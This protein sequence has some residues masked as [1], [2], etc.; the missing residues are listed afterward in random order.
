MVDERI[1]ALVAR[2]VAP[3]KPEYLCAVTDARVVVPPLPSSEE[4]PEVAQRKSKKQ[5][6]RVRPSDLLQASPTFS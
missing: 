5:M 2:G 6:K 3:I 4:P 1:A